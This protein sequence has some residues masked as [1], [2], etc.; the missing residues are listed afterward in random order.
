MRRWVL[1]HSH[2]H[3]QIKRWVLSLIHTLKSGGEL[4]LTHA[5]WNREVS[6]H[7]HTHTKMRRWILTH[8]RTQIRRWFLTHSLKWE[9]EFTVTHSPTFIYMCKWV[10]LLVLLQCQRNQTESVS[11]S[12]N[13]AK[14]SRPQSHTQKTSKLTPNDDSWHV[15]LINLEPS[16]FCQKMRT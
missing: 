12:I 1:S 4:T 11:M 7:S 3:T 8:S 9:G 15:Q 14:S 16:I 10:Y 5:H 2:T 6:S 13:I